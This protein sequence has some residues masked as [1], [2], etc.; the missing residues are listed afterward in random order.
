MTLRSAKQII[1]L[2]KKCKTYIFFQGRNQEL[3]MFC[4]HPITEAYSFIQGWKACKR[5][6]KK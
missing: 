3:P 2:H 5:Q 1:R 4:L 6:I